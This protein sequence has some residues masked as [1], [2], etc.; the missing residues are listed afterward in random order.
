MVHSNV[1]PPSYAAG[2]YLAPLSEEYGRE[3]CSW[4]YEPPYDLFNWP[5]W[6]LM[7]QQGIEF[8]DPV[9]RERQY[10]AI[11]DANHELTG[12]AQFFPLL[13]VTRLGLGL[14]PTLCSQGLGPAVVSLL[15]K[16]A[17]RRAPED[18]V[19]LEVLTWN[20]RAVK[21]YQKAGFEITDRYCRPTPAGTG[22][23]FC[24]IYQEPSV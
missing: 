16:E 1:H 11:L 15:I 2:L 18:E 22:E 23:F 4:R 13:G 3:L 5:S 17:F 10:T 7:Q 6:E 24:M 19:D 8:G 12:Y 20:K 21:A 9:I 14:R